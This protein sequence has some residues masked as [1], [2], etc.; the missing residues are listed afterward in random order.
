MKIVTRKKY[1]LVGGSK[2]KLFGER[3]LINGTI[4]NMTNT[5]SNPRS[6]LKKSDIRNDSGNK[7]DTKL[8]TKMSTSGNTRATKPAATNPHVADTQKRNEAT[9]FDCH[10]KVKPSEHLNICQYGGSRI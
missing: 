10:V 3:H 9:Q 6:R 8:S 1:S 4:W 7:R 2:R 5:G